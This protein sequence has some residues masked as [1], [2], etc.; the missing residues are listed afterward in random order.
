MTYEA[1]GNIKTK[2]DVGTYN[3]TGEKPN[4]VSQIT[5]PASAYDPFH[6]TITYTDFQ[7]VESITDQENNNRL[8]FTYGPDYGRRMMKTLEGGSLKKTK[9][10]SNGIYEKIVNDLDQSKEINYIS[11]SSGLAA[12]FI[13]FSLSVIHYLIARFHIWVLL[14]IATGTAM[15]IALGTTRALQ[16]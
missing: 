1:N 3:Y 8:E 2:P 16:M 11:G 9:Y 6:E 12:V 14:G 4:A 13:Q 15:G 10:Y 5:S 7:K